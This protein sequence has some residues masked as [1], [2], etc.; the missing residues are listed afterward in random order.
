M[1]TEQVKLE[2]QALK[3]ELFKARVMMRRAK[4]L[5]LRSYWT[6]KA[7]H[8]KDKLTTL[9]L[10]ARARSAT[11]RP[12]ASTRTASADSLGLTHTLQMKGTAEMGY[13]L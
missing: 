7:H 10:S 2:K 3:R 11:R 4:T 12:L 5:S 13:G 9:G 6:Q 1:P 8:L